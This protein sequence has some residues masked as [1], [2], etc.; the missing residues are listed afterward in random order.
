MGHDNRTPRSFLPP[1]PS[2]R[3]KSAPH[4][5]KKLAFGRSRRHNL[6]SS[7][8]HP[9]GSVAC[10]PGPDQPSRR[11]PQAT[12]GT[13]E[14]GSSAGAEPPVGSAVRSTLGHGQ[15]SGT[16]LNRWSHGPIPGSPAAASGPPRPGSFSSAGL[17]GALNQTVGHTNDGGPTSHAPDDAGRHDGAQWPPTRWCSAFQPFNP[18][19]SVRSVPSL[20]PVPHTILPSR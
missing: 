12:A 16:G 5:K 13:R 20:T 6:E 2:G 17:A 15:P 10:S 11:L 19:L 1:S 4:A 8:P 18:S 7:V 9:D 14:T 3:R